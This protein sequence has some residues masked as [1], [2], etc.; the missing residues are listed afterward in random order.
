[1]TVPRPTPPDAVLREEREFVHG[2]GGFSVGIS[3]GTLVLNER[4]PVPR[5]NYVCEI[6]VSRHRMAGFFETV[7]DVYFQ[8]ALRPEFHLPEPPPEHLVAVLRQFGFRAWPD[9]RSLLVWDRSIPTPHLPRR[10]PTV[11]R[12]RPEEFGTVVDF[13]SNTRERE[14]LA[15]HLQVLAEHP[16]PPEEIIPI[17]ALEGDRPVASALLHRFGGAWGFHAV[18]TQPDA[19][20]RGVASYLVHASM[21]EILPA[22]SGPVSIRTEQPRALHRLE[23]L[24]FREIAR[25]RVFRLDPDA[26]LT[27]AK[28]PAGSAVPRWRPPRTPASVESVAGASLP[29]A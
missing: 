23:E 20:G 6:A 19:R 13:W 8:R 12:A 1:M 18:A 15:R 17:L 26:E 10:T 2:F 22:T 29:K 24:G 11:R 3:G 5:F 14:E 4:I 27:L 9:P 21:H 16:N 28:G 25:F 7:L